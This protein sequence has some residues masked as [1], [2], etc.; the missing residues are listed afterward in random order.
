MTP[1]SNVEPAVSRPPHG[2]LAGYMPEEEY[3]E[4]RGC[5]KRTARAERQRR[6]GPPYVRLGAAIYYPRD[7]FAAFLKELEVHP[8]RMGRPLGGGKARAQRRR[9]TSD[10]VA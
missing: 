4:V 9:S 2:A 1:M 5:S 6:S 3:C 10:A 7:G 8:R